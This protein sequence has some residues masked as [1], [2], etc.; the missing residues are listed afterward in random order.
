MDLEFNLCKFDV[1]RIKRP[2][3]SGELL[4]D[5]MRFVQ[6]INRI[7]VTGD[8]LRP[9]E[10]SAVPAQ[11][12]N[13]HWLG[14]ILRHPL[15]EA[16]E[17]SVEIRTW[18]T[19]E[20]SDIGGAA[21]KAVYDDFEAPMSIDG[22]AKIF[23]DRS[24]TAAL[25]E[26]VSRIFG[27]AFVVGF[28]LPPVI[29]WSL[30]RNGVPYITMAVHPARY[31]DDILFGMRSNNPAVQLVLRDQA[32]PKREFQFM[33]GLQAAAVQKKSFF[34][35]K[36]NSMLIVGQVPND[37]SCISG[38][39]FAS[40][41]DFR[42]EI[43]AAASMHQ[44]VYFKAHPLTDDK[45][46]ATRMR[47]DWGLAVETTDESIY[48]LL[49]HP[50]V[51][52]VLALSSSVGIE[53]RYFGKESM[54]LLGDADRSW[55][56]DD[57]EVSDAYQPQRGDWLTPDFWRKILAPVMAVTQE[58]GLRLAP[59]VNRLRLSM[60][61]FWGY[62]KTDTDL[63]VALGTEPG[64]VASERIW[65]AART[66]AE[67]SAAALKS[68]IDGVVGAQSAVET[69]IVALKNR[70]DHLDQAQALGRS[71][72]FDLMERVSA[73]E[74]YLSRKLPG[75]WFFRINGRP[76][77]L[78]R[79][80]LFHKS[81]KPRGIFRRLVIKLDGTPRPAFYQWMTSKEYRGLP[82]AWQTN[83]VGGKPMQRGL[84]QSQETEAWRSVLH[85][86]TLDDTELDSLME[87]IRAE[88]RAERA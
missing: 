28:E 44:G 74:T 2:R 79:R 54:L 41:V 61:A 71:A 38:G 25:D 72:M 30:Q 49:S 69:S 19:T 37:A 77:R 23:R 53:A 88:L 12:G 17:R 47:E 26:L 87:R 27:G 86:E 3:F 78:L 36:A 56:N 5:A 59:K 13:I 20:A 1:E 84:R 55:R 21:I 16:T 45:S 33:A 73:L 32:I 52:H 58:D 9:I 83:S 51:R 70:A 76:V 67:T 62:N 11:T 57:P 24:R 43:V 75:R 42:A 18:G 31:L 80:V 35:P 50:N 4:G 64:T 46:V 68:R 60:G 29:E 7:A 66:A 22:W 10:G 81:G 48:Y 40:L 39:R 15:Q 34:Q 63:L 82:K 8:F 6:D 85:K 14:N 65:D